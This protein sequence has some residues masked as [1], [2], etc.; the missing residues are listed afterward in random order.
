MFVNKHKP[1]IVLVFVSR[2]FH[3]NI[4]INNCMVVAFGLSRS[5][6]TSNIFMSVDSNSRTS[7]FPLQCWFNDVI[8]DAVNSRRWS[9][10]HFI[11]IPRWTC[12]P[13]FESLLL[14]KI[15]FIND[16]GGNK[17]NLSK[18]ITQCWYLLF[19]NVWMRSIFSHHSNIRTVK[20]KQWKDNCIS[21]DRDR[22]M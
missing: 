6:R 2:N 8:D 18:P 10:A 21:N 20:S 9:N 16:N 13:S 22:S 1:W 17:L 3:S 12:I 7:Y 11:N 19:E 15:N 4:V 14:K 5:L